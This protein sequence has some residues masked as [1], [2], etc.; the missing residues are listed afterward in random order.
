MLHLTR[1]F[2]VRDLL[3]HLLNYFLL[4]LLMEFWHAIEALLKSA[5]LHGGPQRLVH[6]THRTPPIRDLRHQ[7]F[8]TLADHPSVHHIDLILFLRAIGPIT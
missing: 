2:R 4:D 6:L 7:L 1:L 3:L 5:C 8:L